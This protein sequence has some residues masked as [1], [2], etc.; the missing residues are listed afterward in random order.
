MKWNRALRVPLN[1][2]LEVF[3]QLLKQQAIAHRVTEDQG[4]QVL[5]VAS[6]AQAAQVRELYQQFLAG[7]WPTDAVQPTPT[8]LGTYQAPG[9]IQ[10]LKKQS[11]HHSSVTGLSYRCGD[12]SAG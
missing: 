10:Q 8:P 3:L 12:D 1:A 6:E 9:F 5:W 2:N 7:H 4:E 11:N